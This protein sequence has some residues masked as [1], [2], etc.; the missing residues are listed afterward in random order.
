M[1]FPKDLKEC[2]ETELSWRDLSGRD[3]KIEGAQCR[4]CETIFERRSKGKVMYV[5]TKGSDGYVCGTCGSEIQSTTVAHPIHD[6]PFPLSGSG[7]CEYETVPYC[8]KCEEKPSS[9]GSFI[10]KKFDLGSLVDD[11]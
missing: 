5:K 4:F 2:H 8:P 6:G 1:N 9:S 11:F 10:T 3:Y 7:R